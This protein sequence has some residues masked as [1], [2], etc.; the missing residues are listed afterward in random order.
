TKYPNAVPTRQHA[1]LDTAFYSDCFSFLG[2]LKRRSLFV[3]SI[4]LK[5]LEGNCVN[6]TV[7][8]HLSTH[9]LLEGESLPRRCSDVEHESMKVCATT[10]RQASVML[11]L[12]MSNTNCGFLITFTQNRRGRLWRAENVLMTF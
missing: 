12:W 6:R 3:F 2:I 5:D 11:L 10:D 1:T 7:L 9:S 8:A 4:S